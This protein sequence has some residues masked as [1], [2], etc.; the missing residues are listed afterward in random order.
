LV[1]RAPGPGLLT[2]FILREFQAFGGNLK[3]RPPIKG[4]DFISLYK[5]RLHV[6]NILRQKREKLC[7]FI[8]VQ[9]R[10]D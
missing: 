6:A 4:E 7:D 5:V 1:E 9:Q 3:K 8:F 10:R 2:P